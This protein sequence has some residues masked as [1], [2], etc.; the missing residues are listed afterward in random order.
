MQ[1]SARLEQLFEC[2]IHVIGRAAIPQAEVTKVVGTGPK[3]VKAFNLCNGNNSQKDI[4][5]KTR[6]HQSNLSRT[7]TRWVDAGIAFSIG[8]GK[9]TRLLHVYPLHYDARKSKI[10]KVRRKR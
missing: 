7:F 8:D 10:R 3:Q 6:L 1:D 5:K 9:E 2:L 4:A